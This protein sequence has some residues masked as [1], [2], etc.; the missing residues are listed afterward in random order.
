M[1][2]CMMPL[3][4]A[5]DVKDPSHTPKTQLRTM[6]IGG[7]PVHDRD[8]KISEKSMLATN[9]VEQHDSSFAP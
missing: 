4:Q 3:L 1:T 8:F 7:M 9:L 2:I 6:I 5:C